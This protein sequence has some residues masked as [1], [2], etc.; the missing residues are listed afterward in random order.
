M[1]LYLQFAGWWSQGGTTRM[2]FYFLTFFEVYFSVVNIFGKPHFQVIRN[3]G[4]TWKRNSYLFRNLWSRS[5]PGSIHSYCR[6]GS[7]CPPNS[8]QSLHKSSS[9]SLPVSE[10]AECWIYFCLSRNG[11]S[12]VVSKY[13][14]KRHAKEAA[15][16]TV[17]R[18]KCGPSCFS[19]IVL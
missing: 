7:L 15:A 13:I 5:I 4:Q 12:C 16:S 18:V 10:H 2:Y 19:A 6:C 9:W 8:I 11:G 1:L 17:C 3:S 14:C